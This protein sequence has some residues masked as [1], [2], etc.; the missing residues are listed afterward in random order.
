M[1]QLWAT[2]GALLPAFGWCGAG[3]PNGI[4]TLDVGGAQIE[5]VIVHREEIEDDRL[6][7]LGL[8]AHLSTAD[9]PASIRGDVLSIEPPLSSFKRQQIEAIRRRAPASVDTAAMLFYPLIN[10]NIGMA[11]QLGAVQ[12]GGDLEIIKPLNEALTAGVRLVSPVD[13]APYTLARIEHRDDENH[14][15]SLV[16][17]TYTSTGGMAAPQRL[18]GVSIRKDTALFQPGF[19]TAP[20]LAIAGSA[21]APS[22]IEIFVNGTKT[23]T[24]KIN[25]G[26]FELSGLQSLN[27]NGDVVAVFRDA[28]GKETVQTYQ[29]PGADGLLKAGYTTWGADLG[30]L[31]TG[32]AE[33]GQPYGSAFVR[34]G[35]SN[36]W[37]IG[38]AV[39]A[40]PGD[41]VGYV[42]TS[43]GTPLGGF[44]A[45][46]GSDR[47]GAFGYTA[48][49]GH[50]WARIRKVIEADN[51]MLSASIGS[52][53]NSGS[54]AIAGAQ[55][56]TE[57]R[58]SAS[59]SYKMVGLSI[60][61]VSKPSGEATEF[62]ASINIP[63]GPTAALPSSMFFASAFATQQA[64]TQR[65]AVSTFGP[66]SV[67]A[68]AE[69]ESRKDGSRQYALQGQVQTESM[70]AIAY[71]STGDAGA[72]WSLF[73][74]GA[75]ILGER[76][77]FANTVHEGYV[78]AET[79]TPGA[80]IR[81][82]NREVATAGADGKAVISVPANWAFAFSATSE[83]ISD[84]LKADGV[85][86]AAGMRR[87]ALVQLADSKIGVY[88]TSKA[89]SMATVSG[90]SLIRTSSGFWLEV[91]PGR[92]RL[93]DGQKVVCVDVTAADRNKRIRPAVCDG[94]GQ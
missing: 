30:K 76:P 59:L 72:S 6:I 26:Q 89:P 53:W 16:G 40:Q 46:V 39:T 64:S 24:G 52:T 42:N 74:S 33:Y 85:Q 31:Q 63:F 73:G 28:A 14:V 80:T 90:Q 81:M 84:N 67:N 17:N 25:P 88:V 12:Y 7:G 18:L 27:A 2:L 32:N 41:A 65:L 4:Y 47:Y 36:S 15:F 29:L 82:D 5:G 35:I 70:R 9:L 8:P 3:V 43:L 45:T 1:K 94:F 38:A 51:S 21:K 23:Y 61:R 20:E 57:K 71:G 49:F 50:L 79:G 77:M 78:L 66:T 60:S 62:F 83:D 54:W 37:T 10:Y 58:V 92:H 11:K 91:E 87:G 22:S 13:G 55:T 19:A 68:A 44:S 48:R 56:E 86:A 69:V 75:V 93:L 34:R